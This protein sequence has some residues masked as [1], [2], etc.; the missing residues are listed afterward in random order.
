MA[1]S[2]RWWFPTWCWEW[3]NMSC[4]AKKFFLLQFV[5]QFSLIMHILHIFLRKMFLSKQCNNL[6]MGSYIDDASC[7]KVTRQK[8]LE[9]LAYIIMTVFKFTVNILCPKMC[10]YLS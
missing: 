6:E 5:L 8:D 1:N 2:L 3:K 10:S 4:A 7:S 9:T